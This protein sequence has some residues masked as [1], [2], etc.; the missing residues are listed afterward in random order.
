MEQIF[1]EKPDGIEKE[2]EEIAKE[3][4]M[5]DPLY[6][7]LT[8]EQKEQLIQGELAKIK[9]LRKKTKDN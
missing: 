8:Q 4:V 7:D 9:E 2:F 3:K 5:N 1:K 6:D